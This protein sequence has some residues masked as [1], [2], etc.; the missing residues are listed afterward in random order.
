MRP[1]ALA[2]V[3][4]AVLA[5]PAPARAG[6]RTPP[7]G[8][9]IDAVLVA[10][11]GRAAVERAR[12]VLQEGEVSSAL[13]A[14]SGRLARLYERPGSLRV[15]IAWPDR[16]PEVRVVHRAYGDRDGR[17]VTGTPP[18]AAMVLQAARLDLPFLLWRERGRVVDRGEVTRDGR[19]LRA[20]AVPLPGGI[21]I[22]A[23]IDPATH[24]IVR[25][26]G[27]VPAGGGRVEFATEYSDF[28]EVDGVLF[29]FREESWASGR[30]TGATVLSR[31]QTMS[32]APP[33]TFDEPL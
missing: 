31:V 7:A 5:L 20:L 19:R 24:R 14:G 17:E 12:A 8:A 22:V 3:A 2:L 27:S 25:S 15:E 6:A 4:A 13:H 32:A 21:E 23:E 9:T 16:P 11:G 30:H 26:S 28:R 33:G 10:Y 1:L 29:A 18:H